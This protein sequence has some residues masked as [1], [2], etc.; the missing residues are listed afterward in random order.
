[1]GVYLIY[2]VQGILQ[3]GV[4]CSA[5]H[6]VVRPQGSYLNWHPVAL[7][8]QID[9]IANLLGTTMF[10]SHH[11]VEQPACWVHLQSLAHAG[12]QVERPGW[13]TT[14]LR[15]VQLALPNMH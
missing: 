6:P 3:G 5:D 7:K 11:D 2:N 15:H 12:C 14:L 8:V 10:A 9:D 1:M 4:I 13:V